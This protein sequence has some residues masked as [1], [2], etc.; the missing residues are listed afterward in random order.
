MSESTLRPRRFTLK[1]IFDSKTFEEKTL[2][3]PQWMKDGVRVS[4]LDNAPGTERAT[5][6]TIDSTTGERK[7]LLDPAGLRVEGAEEPRPIHA[8]QWS[9]DEQRLLF[10]ENA[11][12]RFKPCGNLFLYDLADGA[13]RALTQTDEPQYHA[14]FSPDGQ[15]VGVVRS[16]NLW[17]VSVKAGSARQRTFDS[18]PAI[19]NGRLGWVYE[20]E[21]GLADGWA[22]SPDGS[23][24]AYL[25]QDE[26][27][28]PEVLLPQYDDPHAAPLRTRY[29]K[30]GDPNPRIRVGVLMLATGRTQW[31]DVEP[32]RAGEEPA[33]YYLARMQWTPKGDGLLLQRI[34]RLQNRI[35]VLLADPKTGTTRTVFTEEDPA[36]VDLQGDVTFI[37]ETDQ[38]LWLSDRDGWRHLYLYD[39]SGRCLRQVTSGAWDVEKPVGVDAS[40]RTV[41]FTAARSAPIERNVYRVGLDGGDPVCLTAGMPGWHR[42]IFPMTGRGRACPAQ[43]RA[44]QAAPLHEGANSRNGVRFIH[45]HSRLNEP[46]RIDIRDVEGEVCVP[47]VA[48]SLPNLAKFARGVWEP[49]TFA[50]SDGETLYAQILKPLGFDPD[51]RYPALMYTYGGPG[52]QVVTDSWPGT[53]ALWFHL[54]AQ[55]GYVVFMVDNRGTGG[56]GRAFKKQVYLKLGEWEVRDQIEG[57]K[58][59]AALPYVDPKRIGIWGWSYGGYMASLCML[60]GAEVFRAGIAVAPVT[61]WALYDTIYTERY[62][63]RPQDNEAGYRDSAPVTHTK[64]LKGRFLLIHGTMDDNVHFQNAARLAAALQDA[65]RLFETMFYPGK[66]HGIEDRHFHLYATMTAFLK[67]NL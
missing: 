6:W 2:R 23:Q 16:N 8:Y 64:S 57:A 61:D 22:W 63:R 12:A 41:F 26:S 35:D 25:Q 43:E 24:I 54:L 58:Y 37:E 55:Q 19:Y 47:I 66:R 40:A 39:L 59:L 3:Q 46:P 31:V 49:L 9:P 14:K 5:V 53:R 18:A 13:F 7:V 29:P 45:T 17:I 65:K 44:Q 4:Y 34:P 28:V 11:P 1:A 62:M 56:R 32:C 30:A 20:E 52:S 42:A 10:P 50:T 27:E 36:W 15:S 48:D 51:R 67:K 21:L 33:E 60:R 38:F